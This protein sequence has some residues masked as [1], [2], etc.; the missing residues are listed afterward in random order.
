MTPIRS[1]LPV[2]ALVLALVAPVSG[3]TAQQ[4]GHHG[5]HAPGHQ[6]PAGAATPYAGWETRAIK[7][8]SASQLDDL[9][10][11]RGMGLA[12]AAELNGYPGPLHVLE[13]AEPLSLTPEQRALMSDLMVRM[14]AETIAIGRELIEA[15]RQLDTL[16]AERRADDTSLRRITAEIGALGGRLRAAHL[17]YHIATSAALDA[18][19]RRTYASLRGYAP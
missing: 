12:L 15:E 17:S 1:I 5:R 7:A 19:Q 10:N 18:E 2:C 16:F 11:G 4:G 9:A 8:L 13:L 14:K 3:A 6:V